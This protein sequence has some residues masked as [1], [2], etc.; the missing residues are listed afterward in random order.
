VVRSL[1]RKRIEP[2]RVCKVEMRE[3]LGQIGH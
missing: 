3:T 2:T 1:V